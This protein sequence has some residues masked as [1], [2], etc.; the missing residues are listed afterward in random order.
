M[1]NVI[2]FSFHRLE[3]VQEI[4][5]T[6][7]SHDSKKKWERTMEG[8]LINHF[9]LKFTFTNQSNPIGNTQKSWLRFAKYEEHFKVLNVVDYR[10]QFKSTMAKWKKI[11]MKVMA[12]KNFLSL[13]KQS[14]L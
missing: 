5:D 2:S 4:S 12:I 9:Q 13:Q 10:D 1:T 6:L 7:I 14:Y 8:I 3:K 11:S